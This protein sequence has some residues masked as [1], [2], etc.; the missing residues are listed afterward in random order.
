MTLLRTLLPVPN[1]LPQ[2]CI[3]NHLTSALP[4]IDILDTAH[5][6]HCHDS[7]YS[8]YLTSTLPHVWVLELVLHNSF[9][10]YHLQSTFNFRHSNIV[11]CA[12]QSVPD[13][14]SVLYISFQTLWHTNAC[15]T[16]HSTHNSCIIAYH[17][18]HTAW[19]PST[20]HASACVF[21]R[22]SPQRLPDFHTSIY[23]AMT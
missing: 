9:Q 11:L 6:K 12:L 13:T 8:A 3:Y 14:I 20:T 7:V 16:V 17:T 10:I 18:T 5:Q 19:L 21:I 23:H 15:Y 4:H 1:T 22:H 2:Y